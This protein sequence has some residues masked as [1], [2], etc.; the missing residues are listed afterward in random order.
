[1][2]IDQ[3]YKVIIFCAPS[4]AGKSTIIKRMMVLFPNLGFSGSATNRPPREGERDGV[5]YQFLTT[6][7]FQELIAADAFAE[8][9]EV[10][11]GRFYGTLHAEIEKLVAEGKTPVFDVDVKGAVNL[12]KKYGERAI[13]IFIKA[14]FE[15]IE[16]RLIARNTETSET[17]ADRLARVQ[18]ELTYEPYA[19]A[20]IENIDLD[21]AV[22]KTADTIAVFLK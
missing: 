22:D 13:L 16:Q 18:E 21:M 19:D 10:Y 20:V 5:E 8:W 2:D 15:V 3:T 14:P 7:A 11:P 1:M 12:K 9:E 6:E 17:L 4:G